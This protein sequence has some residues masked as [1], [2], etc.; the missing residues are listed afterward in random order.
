MHAALVA[1]AFVLL[2]AANPAAA[3]PD[4][5]SSQGQNHVWYIAA[6]ETLWDYA[7]GGKNLCFRHQK[8][9]SHDEEEHQDTDDTEDLL[10]VNKGL[11][12]FLKKAVYVQYTNDSFQVR[13]VPHPGELHLGDTPHQCAAS[14]VIQAALKS[15]FESFNPV[16]LQE[17]I[18]KPQEFNHTGLLGK[19]PLLSRR[20]CHPH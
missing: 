6:E 19:Q 20:R 16:P 1:I 4:D 7:P 13:A 9:H 11:G 8:G 3:S 5:G 18:P 2:A 17:V 10:W 12:R 14:M 15:L